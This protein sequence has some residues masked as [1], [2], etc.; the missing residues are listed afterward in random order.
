MA[1]RQVVAILENKLSAIRPTPDLMAG[2]FQYF[3]HRYI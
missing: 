1:A 3:N 2:L